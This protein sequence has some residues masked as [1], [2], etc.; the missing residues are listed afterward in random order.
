MASAI[1]GGSGYGSKQGQDVYG[2]W[3]W[4][5]YAM[6]KDVDFG[7]VGAETLTVYYGIGETND[8]PGLNFF[9][10]DY[11]E[12]DV[13][14]ANFGRLTV[15]DAN[16]EE[17][18]AEKVCEINSLDNPSKTGW[19]S[20]DSFTKKF[21]EV[22]TG[23]KSIVIVP[24]SAINLRGIKFNEYVSYEDILNPYKRNTMAE[25]MRGGNYAANNGE[26][27][28]SVGSYNG[29]SWVGF[30]DVNFGTE[31]AKSL[32]LGYGADNTT[33]GFPGI[34]NVYALDNY[35][36]TDTVTASYGALTVTGADGEEK[37]LDTIVAFTKAEDNPPAYGF[38]VEANITKKLSETLTGTKTVFIVPNAVVNLYSI[39]F[40]TTE[41][42]QENMFFEMDLSD[43]TAENAIVKN[44]VTKNTTGIGVYKDEASQTYYPELNTITSAT[45][46]KKYITIA[47]ED[48][49]GN[50][51]EKGFINL[52]KELATPAA[53]AE[54]LTIETWVRYEASEA[55]SGK[56]KK[57]FS[58]SKN[59]YSLCPNDNNT[60]FMV[61]TGADGSKFRMCTYNPSSSDS[62]LTRKNYTGLTKDKW[63]H[64]VITKSWDEANSAYNIK[65]F[66]DGEEL[67]KFSSAG[68]FPDV[69]GEENLQIGTVGNSKGKSFIGSIGDFK[70][71]ST[72]LSLTSAKEK[73]EASKDDYVELSEDFS[74]KSPEFGDEINP[75]AQ[76][77][78]VEFTNYF[79]AE[80]AKR[81][82]SFKK[83]VGDGVYEDINGGYTIEAGEFSNTAKIRFGKLEPDA[84]YAILF[85]N[86][87][88]GNGAELD[89]DCVMVYTNYGEYY[90]N[91]DF[92]ALENGTNPT[93]EA[94]G[95]TFKS[96]GI[97]DSTAD[98]YVR[99]TAGGT[100][101]LEMNSTAASRADTTVA[102]KFKSA[103]S[104]PVMFEVGVKGNTTT[105][106]DARFQ[107]GIRVDGSGKGF[108]ALN[109][110]GTEFNMTNSQGLQITDKTIVTDADGFFNMKYILFPSEAGLTYY[111]Y[112]EDDPDF[113]AKASMDVHKTIGSLNV[114]QYLSSAGDPEMHVSH[115]KVSDYVPTEIIKETTYADKKVSYTFNY[116]ID[117][118]TLNNV[119][120]TDANGE[121]VPAA[122]SYSQALRQVT[123]TF[124]KEIYINKLYTVSF[125]GVKDAAG[126][127]IPVT[128]DIKFGSE[129]IGLGSDIV[130]SCTEGD[131][132]SINDMSAS[133]DTI[134][135]NFNIVNMASV[136]NDISVMMA[137]YD[138]GVLKAV[139]MI[140]VK[141]LANGVDTP[142]EATLTTGAI[143]DLSTCE[144][145]VFVWDDMVPVIDPWYI[146]TDGVCLSQV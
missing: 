129:L 15:T 4:D 100:K 47:T 31:G 95:L 133:G 121:T 104:T 141:A 60:W 2:G 44:T 110:A 111:V 140:P 26:G 124:E 73:Y 83:E 137:L 53:Q 113:Y 109:S 71:Y 30:K 29:S 118:D 97:Q 131:M 11:E 76:E 35:E 99:E 106:P 92:T 37:A 61:D 143:D 132:V 112:S 17:K 139:S 39:Q 114:Q 42:Y 74:V 22:M 59:L 36:D 90:I 70:M 56:Y 7:D 62:Q 127:Y 87:V 52:Y 8:F 77:L 65:I 72:A 9:A 93:S 32:T 3:S 46:T 123:L 146:N 144:I 41:E 43:Y 6:F 128:T 122:V 126:I 48:A 34:I 96:S 55:N 145:K 24:S 33:Y 68:A 135:A 108:G 102:Y 38:S 13:L 82:I 23:V 125:E 10:I 50:I 1:G 49:E 75:N 20:E 12:G 5:S 84:P 117:E 57:L 16:G 119:A 69:T 91:T 105:N 66:R 115:I 81:A 136:D 63:T 80:E 142:C 40:N 107:R 19:N 54:D 101:Y 86:M 64:L 116:D 89:T 85:D 14:T 25:T 78:T 51:T 45:G 28:D 88:A 94:T 120:V 79:T 130:F 27:S 67:T 98:I 18:T 103:I 138:G 134:Y 58:L 21:S